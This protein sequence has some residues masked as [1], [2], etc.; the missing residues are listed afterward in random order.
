MGVK[1]LDFSR[2]YALYRNLTGKFM[3]VSV[4]TLSD[5]D[6]YNSKKVI[7]LKCSEVYKKYN[8][9]IEQQRA[10]VSSQRDSFDSNKKRF[11]ALDDYPDGHALIVRPNG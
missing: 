3:L 7:M 4:D 1:R 2:P 8:S 10:I 5:H 9:S 6:I 11:H